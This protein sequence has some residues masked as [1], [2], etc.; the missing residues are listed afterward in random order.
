METTEFYAAIARLHETA[1]P[2]IAGATT[3]E[4]WTDR[5]NQLVGRKSG[6]LAELMAVLPTLREADRR[7]AGATL[8]ELKSEIE[9]LQIGRAHV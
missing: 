7:L 2:K 8:N 6:Q 4:E 5:R 9:S 3:L 1:P